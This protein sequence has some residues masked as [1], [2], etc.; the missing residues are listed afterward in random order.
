MSDFVLRPGRAIE[1]GLEVGPG[2]YT[3]RVESD[4]AVTASL[5]DA[6]GIPS[7]RHRLEGYAKKRSRRT[8]AIRNVGT[9]SK[10]RGVYEVNRG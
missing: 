2:S 1:L 5:G 4:T 7:R 6:D 9:K 8:L 10:A 3:I